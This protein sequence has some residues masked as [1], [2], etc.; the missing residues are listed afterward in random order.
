M[1]SW[2][3]A[4]IL[5]AEDVALAA[6]GQLPLM[7]RAATAVALAAVRQLGTPLRGRRVVLLVGVG[8]NGGDALFAGANL[9]RRGLRVHAVCTDVDRAH[10]AGL[11]AFRRAGGRV[12]TT[13]DAPALLGRADLIVDGLVGIGARPPLRAAAARLVEL[14][15][16]APG[17]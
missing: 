1:H 3:V 10:A 5:A 2:T 15:N 13:D 17:P 16:A 9:A 12:A 6:Q 14:A 11:D 4:Q 7:K 8:N